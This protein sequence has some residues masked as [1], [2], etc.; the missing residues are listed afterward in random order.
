VSSVGSTTWRPWN[1][2]TVNP[3]WMSAR[4]RE[5]FGQLRSSFAEIWEEVL[6]ATPRAVWEDNL[7]RVARALRAQDAAAA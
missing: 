5:G 2:A 6:P 4:T 3:R 7:D 1:T